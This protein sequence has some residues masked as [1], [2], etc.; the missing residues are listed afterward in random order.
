MYVTEGGGDSAVSNLLDPA[1]A[2][3]VNTMAQQHQ[4]LPPCLSCPESVALYEETQEVGSVSHMIL[5]SSS[6]HST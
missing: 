3:S 5:L 2:M 6:L 1:M 4:A